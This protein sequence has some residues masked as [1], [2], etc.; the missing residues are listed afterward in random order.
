MKI[1]SVH[2]PEVLYLRQFEFPGSPRVKPDLD[3]GF[4]S[5]SSKY[6]PSRYGDKIAPDRA[7]KALPMSHMRED[8][9]IPLELASD[10]INP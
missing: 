9:Q 8:G 5:W 1:P 10:K 3:R 2:P 7:Y 6:N 4:P